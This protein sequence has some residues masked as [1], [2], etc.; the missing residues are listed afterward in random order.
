M[1][2]GKFLRGSETILIIDDEEMILDVGGELI[3]SLGYTVLTAQSG[4][5]AIEIY[6]ENKDGI[7]MVVLDMI[8][9]EMGGG[10]TFDKLREV[11]PKVKVLLSSG[12]SL[13]GQAKEILDRGC[14][15]FI[16]KPFDLKNLS[17]IV[18]EI[19]GK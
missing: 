2:K 19:L 15:G 5:E 16:Q 4:S 3:S 12:Y 1:S 6:K 13:D 10:T 17:K 14:D 18:R 11:D 9:P 8:M 7:H